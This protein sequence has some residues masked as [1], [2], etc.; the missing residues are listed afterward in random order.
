MFLL[1]FWSFFIHMNLKLELG[2]LTRLI[3]GPQLHRI[4]HSILVQH[5][6]K[7][8][9]AYFPIWDILFETYHSPQK[10]EFPAT[11]LISS[12]EKTPSI[13]IVNAFLWPVRRWLPFNF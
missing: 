4:H 10:G 13:S 2:V 8:F 12:N 5:K 11:G 9:S 6:N 7:N 1:S 3:T